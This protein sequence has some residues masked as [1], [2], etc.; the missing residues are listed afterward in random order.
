MPAKIRYNINNTG[1]IPQTAV[2]R[3][4]A[5]RVPAKRPSHPYLQ[6]RG[7]VAKK[8]NI[9]GRFG[10]KLGKICVLHKYINKYAVKIVQNMG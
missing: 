4:A 9:S 5:R 10:K 8:C 2:R 3:K 1:M 7:S 6:N